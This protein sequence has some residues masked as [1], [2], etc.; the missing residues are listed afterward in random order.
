METIFGLM[1]GL[2]KGKKAELV[3]MDGNA[4]SCH[5]DS[6]YGQFRRLTTAASTRSGLTKVRRASS[7]KRKSRL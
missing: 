3:A 2:Q 5:N 1:G 6:L 4:K 7:E